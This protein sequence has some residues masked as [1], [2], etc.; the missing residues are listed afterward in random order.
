[1]NN[2]ST[3]IHDARSGFHDI[4]AIP[5][6]FPSLLTWSSF[7]ALLIIFALALL[8]FIIARKKKQLPIQPER[9][10]SPLELAYQ[11]M[12]ILFK[13]WQAQT[14]SLR[15]LSSELS[16]LVR[17][18]IDQVWN[19]PAD[20]RTAKE[21]AAEFETIVKHE[22]PLLPKELQHVLTKDLLKVL[23]LAEELTFSKSAA[24]S[25]QVTQQIS[26]LFTQTR[27]FV[28]DLNNKINKEK[29]RSATVM[30]SATGG[31]I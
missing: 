18:F 15:A 6:F 10:L 9:K 23:R 28:T 2:I 31:R 12:D 27:A 29:E 16:L 25:E 1:M 14:I 26:Q 5:D 7:L 21:I 20:D 24:D 11:Q 4:T 8:I 3:N 22:L 30:G 13:Q 19:F 17:S